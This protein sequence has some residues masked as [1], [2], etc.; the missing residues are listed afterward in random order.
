M[1]HLQRTEVR[2]V[3]EPFRAGQ[4]GSSAMPHKRNPIT[5]ERLSGLARVLRA[6]VGPGLEDV[7]LWHERDIS[8]SSVERVILP[9][10]SLLADYVL[11]KMRDV[12]DGLRVHPERM[13]ENIDRSHGLV[14]SQPVLLAL[15]AA[16]LSRDDAYRVV[17]DVA[18]AAWEQ[19]RS[20]RSLLEADGRVPLTAEQLDEAFSLERALRNVGPVFDALEEVE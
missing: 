14:F 4:K 16:G 6:N 8:H 12:V 3:E 17:Q 11:A 18:M 9:D 5:C 1:R 15:V 19:G 10:S 13:L 20:F 2:E 7:A